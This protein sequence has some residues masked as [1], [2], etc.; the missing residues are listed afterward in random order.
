[1]HYRRPG[2][3]APFIRGD[4]F[5]DTPE[6]V[7]AYVKDK[8][9]QGH[10]GSNG[11]AGAAPPIN[12][13]PR[14]TTFNA[15]PEA[16]ITDVQEKERQDRPGAVGPTETSIFSASTTADDGKP[17]A[18]A[19]EN[20][21][22]ETAM[23]DMKNK[24][25]PEAKWP[26]VVKQ[27]RKNG[28]RRE[29]ATGVVD[30]WWIRPYGKTPTQGGTRAE[31]AFTEE[32]LKELAQTHLGWGGEGDCDKA[33]RAARASVQRAA[34]LRSFD[35]EPTGQKREAASTS[36][37]NTK[38]SSGNK[39]AKTDKKP[40]AGKKP[41]PTCSTNSPKS[42]KKTKQPKVESME[43]LNRR[44]NRLTKQKSRLDGRINELEE[45]LRE[46]QRNAEAIRGL[47]P[48]EEDCS[49]LGEHAKGR[50]Q[51]IRKYFVPLPNA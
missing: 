15:S 17:A 4:D 50:M 6:E 33:G 44:I 36:T 48:T 25:G 49:A 38:R 22:L 31:D 45:E 7:I 13:A 43:T 11:P 12:D 26:D 51:T 42:S 2:G 32:E 37:G 30:S 46:Y 21:T 5:F 14:A 47:L 35:L 29:Y 10:Q 8:E 1:V 41:K 28:W 16:T 20:A 34:S 40:S 9:S 27:F 39:R 18:E 24:F 3:F 19:S 23:H